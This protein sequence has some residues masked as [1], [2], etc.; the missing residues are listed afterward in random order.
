MGGGAET[1]AMVAS[2]LA[3]ERQFHRQQDWQCHCYCENG[4]E[5]RA[6]AS[7][8][9]SLSSS[10]TNRGVIDREGFGRQCLQ[11]PC[12]AGESICVRGAARCA[13]F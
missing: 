3:V 11:Q 13:F 6:H 12:V 7:L 10:G 1:F 4:Q 2:A 9:G 5:L 8:N